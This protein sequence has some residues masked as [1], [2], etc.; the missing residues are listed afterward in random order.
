M[1]TKAILASMV[2]RTLVALALIVAIGLLAPSAA[3]A[4]GRAMRP[5]D[6]TMVMELDSPIQPGEYAWDETGAPAGPVRIVVDL[7]KEKL[8]VYR[9]GVEIGRTFILYGVDSKPTPTGVF[10]IL[11]KDADHYSSTYNHAPMP[12]TLRLTWGGVSIHGSDVDPKYGTHGCIGVP[13]EFARIL[14]RAARKGDPVLVTR[15]WM[16]SIYNAM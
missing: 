15:N 2:N 11:Q 5:V 13:V 8:Y 10:P 3:D 6:V 4:K 16:P 1:R 7:A 9:G 12:Y 14:F